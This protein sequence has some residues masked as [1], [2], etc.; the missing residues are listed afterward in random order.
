MT[1]K[2]EN[3]QLKTENATLREQVRVLL[4]RVLLKRVQGLEAPLAKDSHNSSKPPSSD[5]LARK[6]RSLRKRSGK[7]P[8][9]QIRASWGDAAAGGP[10]GRRG[11]HHPTLCAA[12]QTPLDED[13]PVVTRELRQVHE[14]PPL[15]LRITEHRALHVRCPTC[16]EVS[17]GAF[18]AEASSRAQYRPRLRA[19][20]SISS[21]I[22]SSPAHACGNCSRICCALGC[23]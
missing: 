23:P 20:R 13:A 8:G 10:A 14:L 4:K 6:T 11:E 2:D 12:R 21:N 7:M 17:M 1:P 18:P 16:Q 15:R 3:A 22:N 9:G 5:G 19:L